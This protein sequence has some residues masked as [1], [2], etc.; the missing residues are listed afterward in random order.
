M[1]DKKS[2][3]MTPYLGKETVCQ[4]ADSCSLASWSHPVAIEEPFN[5]SCTFGVSAFHFDP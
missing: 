3:E 1:A 5:E 4:I 2:L